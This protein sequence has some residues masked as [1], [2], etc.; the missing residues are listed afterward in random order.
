M[1]YTLVIERLGIEKGRAEGRAE[2]QAE[3]L[4]DQIQHRFGAVPDAIAQ[5]VQS[6]QA[7]QLE[8]WS[9][10]FVDATTLEDVFRD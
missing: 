1:G 4:L 9:L 5:R 2:G 10:N 6:A 7:L 3:L 8:T